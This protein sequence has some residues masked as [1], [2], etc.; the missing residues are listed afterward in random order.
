MAEDLASHF[1]PLLYC[2][3]VDAPVTPSEVL[4]DPLLMCQELQTVLD[5][6]YKGA[7]SACLCPVLSHCL[8]HLTLPA[9]DVLA[10][11]LQLLPYHGLLPL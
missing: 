3:G 4:L 2:Q 9:F 10:L 8:L 5:A 1:K 7:T 11:W 6:N